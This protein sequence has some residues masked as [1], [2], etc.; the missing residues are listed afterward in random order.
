MDGDRRDRSPS[1]APEAEADPELVGPSLDG[2]AKDGGASSRARSTGWTTVP[3]VISPSNGWRRNVNDVA[4][5]KFAP[6]PRR[7]Q[8]SSG[9]SSSL[10][11]TRRPSAVTSSTERRL[12]IVSPCFRWSRPMPPPRVSPATPVCETTPTGQTSPAACACSSS[13]ARSAPPATRAV[14]A[15]GSTVHASH[16]G[17]VD[18]DAVIARREARDAVAAAPDGDEQILLAGEP[19]RRDDVID[20]RRSDDQRR[21]P[22]D[23]PVPHDARGVV[24]R[25]AGT[26]DLAVEA[27]VEVRQR[28]S[29]SRPARGGVPPRPRGPSARPS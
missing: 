14:R 6:A 12:S 17:E 16:P 22:V 13:S 5:P 7:P 15:P 9:F 21:V 24:A 26:D 1:A 10:A 11:R 23:E 29:A 18:H 20:V 3:C 8:K 2:L 19:K 28:R 4:I 27:A 25:V